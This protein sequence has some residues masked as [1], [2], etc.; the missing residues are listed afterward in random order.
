MKGFS[1]RHLLQKLQF[2]FDSIIRRPISRM[3]GTEDSGGFGKSGINKTP[4]ELT[5]EDWKKILSPEQYYV[6]R[7]QGT[8][9]PFT[10]KYNQFNEEGTY[11]C[12]CCGVAL[13]DSS[14]KFSSTCGWPAFSSVKKNEPVVDTDSENSNVKR[15]ADYSHGIERVEVICKN[16]GAH[17]GH[18][19]DDGPKPSGERFC[20]NSVSL[21]FQPNKK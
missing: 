10:G 8:E 19:F 3:S 13:F 17:L 11:T 12:A 5:R 14:A 15:R 21:N 4:K 18:V 7:E 16:C 9:R 6:C 1:S 20:I 2:T